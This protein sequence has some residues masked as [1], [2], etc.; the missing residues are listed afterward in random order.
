[1]SPPVRVLLADSNH[2]I[3]LGVR[4]VLADAPGIDL[5]PEVTDGQGLKSAVKEQQPDVLLLAPGVIDEPLTTI[6]AIIHEHSV[7]THILVMLSDCTQVCWQELVDYGAAGCLL[8]SEPP[9]TFL[10][11]LRAVAAGKSWFSQELVGTILTSTQ[12]RLTEREQTVLQLVVAEKTDR[13]ISQMVNLSPRTVRKEL[14]SI[15]DKLEVNS[16]VGAAYQAGKWN[17]V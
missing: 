14:R 3:R 10:E 12:I 8:K 16:R 9:E 7:G 17:L 4:A 5:L 15:Y 13:E 6:L 1:M 11:A 2:L